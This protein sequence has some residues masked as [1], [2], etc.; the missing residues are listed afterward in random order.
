MKSRDAHHDLLLGPLNFTIAVRNAPVQIDPKGTGL[1]AHIAVEI[2]PA[3]LAD[4]RILPSHAFGGE[5]HASDAYIGI[6]IASD[7]CDD[8]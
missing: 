8:W 1:G 3:V 2:E 4:L 7:T 5:F 6:A